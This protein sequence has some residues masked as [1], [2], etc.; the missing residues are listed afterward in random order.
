MAFYRSSVA[1]Y[2]Q[3]PNATIFPI[4][5]FMIATQELDQE[6]AVY[7]NGIKFIPILFLAFYFGTPH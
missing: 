3:K 1:Q 7:D 2:K 5:E 4:F 6:N